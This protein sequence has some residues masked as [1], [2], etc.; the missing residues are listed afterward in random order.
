MLT[1]FAKALIIGLGLAVLAGPALGAPLSALDLLGSEGTLYQRAA[2]QVLKPRCGPTIAPKCLKGY[3]N[4]C[5]A[6]DNRGCCA[7]SRCER[8]R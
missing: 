6:Y 2:G 8:V 5:V 3:Q 4:Q 1:R 7:H